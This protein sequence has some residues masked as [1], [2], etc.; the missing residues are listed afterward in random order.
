VK[1]VGYYGETWLGDVPRQVRE[2]ESLG[3]DAISAPELKHNSILALTL[4][5]EHTVRRDLSGIAP[6]CRGS[7]ALA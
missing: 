4:A 2:A 6:R 7:R 5:A 3:L 1:V